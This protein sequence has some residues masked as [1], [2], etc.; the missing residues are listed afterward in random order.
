MKPG[1][2]FNAYTKIKPH[3]AIGCPC[4]FVWAEKDGYIVHATCKDLSENPGED[5]ERVFSKN[6]FD[7]EEIEKGHP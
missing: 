7:F 4:T 5:A 3:L 2:K 1:D 6:D